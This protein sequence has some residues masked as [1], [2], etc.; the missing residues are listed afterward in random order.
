MASMVGSE[1]DERIA[2][3]FA[4]DAKSEEVGLLMSML[5]P[6]RRWPRLRLRM[7]GRVR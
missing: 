2:A 1:L 3:A 4:E 5:R 7:R 6:R